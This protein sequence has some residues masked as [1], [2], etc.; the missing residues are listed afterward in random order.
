MKTYQKIITGLIIALPLFLVSCLDDPEPYYQG[1]L[2]TSP[3]NLAPFN[4]EF[5]DYNS[6]APT[7]GSLIPFC[8]STN[9]QSSG[10]NFDIIYQPMTVMFSQISGE[11]AIIKGYSSWS[12]YQPILDVLNQAVEKVNTLGNEFGPYLLLNPEKKTTNEDFLLLYATD[13]N[14]KFQVGY[15]HNVNSTE[16]IEGTPIAALA[17]DYNDLYPSFNNDF[18][19]FYLCSDRENDIFN[20]YYTP[21]EISEGGFVATLENITEMELTKVDVLSSTYDDKCPFILGNTMVFASNRPGGEGGYDLYYS[22]Y[23]ND[24]W[25]APVNFGPTINSPDDEYRPILIEEYVDLDRYML[26]FSSNRSGGKGGYDLYFV[27]VDK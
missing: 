17:S 2:P 13:V 25:S 21:F 15:T 18:S 5:D 10:E 4:T 23:E 6:T 8:F 26:I 20:I 12:V 3:V 14:G 22:K 11:L 7:L 19:E 24:Q 16:F 27:G 1:E 9:R